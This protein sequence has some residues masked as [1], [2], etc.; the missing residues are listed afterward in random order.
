M[1]GAPAFIGQKFVE[2]EDKITE[3]EQA[4]YCSGVGTLLN[5]TEHSRP[6]ITN[7]VRELSKVW[8]VH[9]SYNYKNSK[10][11]PSLC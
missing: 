7:A 8:F 6:D 5:L 1:P 4:S 2:E 9:P 11:L 10:E 3:K